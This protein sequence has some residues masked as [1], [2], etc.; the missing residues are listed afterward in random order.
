M[1]QLIRRHKS[2]KDA[3]FTLIEMLIVVVVLGILSGIAVFAVQSLTGTS[4]QAAC[5]SD[6]KTVEVAV[7][8]YKAQLGIYP[9]Q[10]QDGISG[11]ATDA[12]MTSTLGTCSERPSSSASAISTLSLPYMRRVWS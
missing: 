5:K 4:V 6:Y 11:T 7:E 2:N 10:G 9:T 12:V 3:G 8:A 1:S